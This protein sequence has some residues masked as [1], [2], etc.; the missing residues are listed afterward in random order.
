MRAIDA[1]VPHDI[2]QPFP[3]PIDPNG[4]EMA[5]TEFLTGWQDKSYG[6]MAKYAVNPTDQPA[7]KMAGELRQM[8]E[9]VELI[10]YEF[11]SF[12]YTSVARCDVRIWAKAKMLTKDVEGEFDLGPLRFTAKGDVA[13]P[14][15]KDGHWC[16][17]QYCIY[18]VMNEKFAAPPENG[19][20]D[21]SV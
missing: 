5:A 15:D 9:Y 3:Q 7:N 8:A 12:R 21:Q 19:S 20:S 14:S 10:A 11:R 6:K 2:A 4:P 17:Q 13:T 16:V 1:F 18:S